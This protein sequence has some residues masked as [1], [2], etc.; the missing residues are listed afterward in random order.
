MLNYTKTCSIL[1]AHFTETCKVAE[2]FVK[3]THLLNG[4]ILLVHIGIASMRQF[5]C[6]SPTYVTEIKETYKAQIR[7]EIKSLNLMMIMMMMMMMMMMNREFFTSCFC[8][9]LEIVVLN[10]CISCFNSLFQPTLPHLDQ[11]NKH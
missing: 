3:N 1:R 6:V 9:V 4:H 8:I 2:K 11:Y 5:Q 10:K 7:T